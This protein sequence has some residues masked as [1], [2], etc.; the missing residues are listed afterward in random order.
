MASEKEIVHVADKLWWYARQNKDD[1]VESYQND[2]GLLVSDRER[3]IALARQDMVDLRKA[4]WLLCGEGTV[5]A[6]TYICGLDT[7]VRESI[8]RDIYKFIMN[9]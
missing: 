2:N 1:M 8:P 3:L 7:A 9:A 5:A 6:A 4:A